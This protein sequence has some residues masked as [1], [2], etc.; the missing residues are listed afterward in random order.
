MKDD[1]PDPTATFHSDG[2]VRGN[3][4]PEYD[5]I[6]DW[7]EID[8]EVE[9]GMAGEFLTNAWMMKYGENDLHHMKMAMGHLGV[10]IQEYLD[11]GADREEANE[12]REDIINLCWLLANE[13]ETFEQE[14]ST[15]D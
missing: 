10:A 11:A 13:L 3:V 12:L 7:L 9:D 8:G 15:K 6:L 1:A 4:T 14:E 2:S 5:D